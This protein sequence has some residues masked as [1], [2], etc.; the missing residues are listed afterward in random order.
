MM[1]QGITAEDVFRIGIE[2]EKNGRAFYVKAASTAA[3]AAI[4]AK[5]TELAGWEE[6]HIELFDRLCKALPLRASNLLLFDPDDEVAL[7]V[8]AMA[9]SSVFTKETDAE[10]QA[11]RCSTPA[12]ILKLALAFEKE[13]VVL[14]SSLREAVAVDCGRSEIEKLIHEE[15]RHVGILTGELKKLR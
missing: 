13:S 7:Y 10:A 5:L 2:I 9:D 4:K 12:E 15:L 6:Q 11:A 3:G 14:Y 1:A 8:K